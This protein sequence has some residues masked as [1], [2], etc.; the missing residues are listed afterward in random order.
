MVT[1]GFEPARCRC[2]VPRPNHSVTMLPLKLIKFSLVKIGFMIPFIIFL[3]IIPRLSTFSGLLVSRLQ[4]SIKQLKN[5]NE[6]Q[7]KAL[8]E[9][10]IEVKEM[11][12]FMKSVSIMDTRLVKRYVRVSCNQLLTK[13]LHSCINSEFDPFSTVCNLTNHEKFL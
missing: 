6:E 10:R 12:E 2:R 4:Q 13:N 7:N 1:A 5:E 3:F 9:A 8:E 11:R